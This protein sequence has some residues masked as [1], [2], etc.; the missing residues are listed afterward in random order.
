M[1]EHCHDF[2]ERLEDMISHALPADI[3]AS[4]ERHLI[5][6]E[7][8]RRYH[9][10]LERD[11]RMLLHSFAESMEGLASRIEE[12]VFRSRAQCA[13]A[14]PD[15]RRFLGLR[16]A[17]AVRIAAAIAVTATIVLAW[18]LFD[19]ST[20]RDVVWAEV[21]EKIENP[22]TYIAKNQSVHDGRLVQETVM[23]Y[24]PEFGYRRDTFKSGAL[25]SQSFY[26]LPVNRKYDLNFTDKIC[27]TRELSPRSLEYIRERS[28][29]GMI[30]RFKARDYV[31]LG[32]SKIEDTVVSGIEITDTLQGKNGAR[33]SIMRIY[34]DP[35]TNLPI[36]FERDGG[37]T[38]RQGRTTYQWR[39]KLTSEDFA[40]AIPDNFF[41]ADLAQPIEQIIASAIRGLRTFTRIAGRYPEDIYFPRLR[42]EVAGE[43]KRLEQAGAY[44][45]DISD[46]LN[47]VLNA[48][49]LAAWKDRVPHFYSAGEFPHYDSSVAPGDADKVLYRW[50]MD[51]T[52][53]IIYGDL[54]F[55]TGTAGQFEELDKKSME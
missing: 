55:G 35:A 40:P 50:R 26:C 15:K 23:R 32:T 22:P 18:H 2:R 1:S 13:L 43:M 12:G 11:D 5:E 45:P 29:L 3:G 20:H 31:P 47:T 21:F 48:G 37:I 9:Q 51:D 8:C 36:L 41:V 39:P 28:L 19:S 44:S 52:I 17:S 46:S 53:G 30:A 25:T 16:V 6:C 14:R 42:Q 4:V 38:R 49:T 34:V 27:L 33:I 24:S 7:D 54:R 10:A